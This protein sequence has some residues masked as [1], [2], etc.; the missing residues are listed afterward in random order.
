ME[1]VDHGAAAWRRHGVGGVD[2]LS[3]SLS[4]LVMGLMYMC[5]V[6]FGMACMIN[7]FP[8]MFALSKILIPDKSMIGVRKDRMAGRSRELTLETGDLRGS[9][10]S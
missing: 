8:R 9:R 3:S 10:I 7:F 6:A 2:I 1:C 5:S 4:I